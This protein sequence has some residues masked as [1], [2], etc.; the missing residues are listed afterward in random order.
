MEEIVLSGLEYANIYNSSASG[1]RGRG[2]ESAEQDVRTPHC[3]GRYK[4]AAR[5]ARTVIL[6]L[7]EIIVSIFSILPTK[8]KILS[9]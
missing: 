5:I 2:F 4:S 6:K 7:T 3:T 8:T 1:A 9:T